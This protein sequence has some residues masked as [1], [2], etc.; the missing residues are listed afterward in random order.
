MIVFQQ[1]ICPNPVLAL[2]V[3]DGVHAGHRHIV[4]TACRLAERIGGS[5]VAVTFDPHPRQIVADGSPEL[6]LPLTERKRLL[7]EAGAAQV[8]TIAFDAGVSRLSPEEFC[9]RLQSETGCRGIVTG[10]HWRFGSGGKGDRLSLE[11]FASP[12]G[13]A[14]ESPRELELN[15]VVISSSAIRSLI[16]QGEL[17]TAREMLGRD[18]GVYGQVIHGYR[19]AG[20]LLDAPTANLQVEYGVLPPDG[21]YAGRAVVDGVPH[22]AVANLG[23]SPTFDRGDADR[24]LEIHLLDGSGDLYGKNIR[25]DFVKFLRRERRFAS[26]EELKRQIKSDIEEARGI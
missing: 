17:A 26:V 22:T 9:L 18:I 20:S 23:F 10:E 1:K 8:A 13:I 7:V 16:A 5:C 3:F 4:A 21:V 25:F 15:G 6:L 19:D 12:R 24:R 11:R 14:V 2:G